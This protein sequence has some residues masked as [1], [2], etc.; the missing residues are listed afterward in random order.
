MS[1]FDIA[2]TRLLVTIVPCAA[3][4]AQLRLLRAVMA[5]AVTVLF[6]SHPPN[7]QRLWTFA[8]RAWRAA[9]GPLLHAWHL[10]QIASQLGGRSGPR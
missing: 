6:F 3:P 1:E 10:L 5:V 2:A 7:P 8:G 4:V 9:R